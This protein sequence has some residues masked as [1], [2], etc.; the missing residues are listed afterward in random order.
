MLSDTRLAQMIKMDGLGTNHRI[1]KL[2]SCFGAGGGVERNVNPETS[3]A[4]A[5]AAELGRLGYSKIRVG[6]FPGAWQKGNRHRQARTTNRRRRDGTRALTR[7]TPL[8]R[9]G[10]LT[11]RHRSSFD[12][13][14]T[15]RVLYKGE[16]DPNMDSKPHHSQKTVTHAHC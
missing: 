10:R 5:I 8:V 2:N 6:G 7:Q 13:Q 4:A 15:H 11:G 12:S 14:L 3:F 16:A 9:T 1:I